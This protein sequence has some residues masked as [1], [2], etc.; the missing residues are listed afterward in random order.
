MLVVGG[1]VDALRVGRS[2]PATNR[3]NTRLDSQRRLAVARAMIRFLPSL[4]L[5]LISIKNDR[6]FVCPFSQRRLVP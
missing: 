6:A 1:V 5:G 3:R 2:E 4:V